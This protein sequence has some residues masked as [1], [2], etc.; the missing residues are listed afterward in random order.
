MQRHYSGSKYSISHKSNN[1]SSQSQEIV[2]K[3]QNGRES[4]SSEKVPSFEIKHPDKKSSSVSIKTLGVSD[5]AH[6]NP[7]SKFKL[8]DSEKEPPQAEKTIDEVKEQISDKAKNI[9]NIIINEEN[10]VK[11]DADLGKEEMPVGQDETKPQQQI[12]NKEE[13]KQAPEDI[14]P[15]IDSHNF[16]D[17]IKESLDFATFL[18]KQANDVNNLRDSDMSDVVRVHRHVEELVNGVKKPQKTN[19]S[20]IDGNKTI[21][22]TL[23]FIL[24]ES[25]DSFEVPDE[26]ELKESII[27]FER[28][29]IARQS[30]DLLKSMKD[31]IA[32]AKVC[33]SNNDFKNP[34]L[35]SVQLIKREK[36]LPEDEM[37]RDFMDLTPKQSLTTQQKRNERVETLGEELDDLYDNYDDMFN[38]EDEDSSH[39]DTP[40]GYSVYPSVLDTNNGSSKKIHNVESL[41]VEEYADLR[42]N[43]EQELPFDIVNGSSPSLKLSAKS[44]P[45][46]LKAPKEEKINQNLISPLF[47]ASEE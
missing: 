31:A 12:Q 45:K 44:I 29:S 25:E 9:Q 40:K 26:K 30:E 18:K 3:N 1:S 35:K 4:V 27:K 39:N 16:E 21:R 33:L 41:D 13:V 6:K 19:R 17:S 8:F 7:I 37:E 28:H 23:D 46:I 2:L 15:K 43:K 5:S 34:M 38:Y 22:K 20:S 11:A 47:T 10:E 32:Q 14:T 24:S 36:V 42:V